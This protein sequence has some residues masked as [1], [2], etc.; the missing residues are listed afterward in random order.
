MFEST[1]T[2]QDAAGAALDQGALVRLLGELTWAP[3]TLRDGRYVRWEPVDAESA[4]AFLTV[5]GRQVSAVFHFGADGL[6]EGFTAERF[7]D[8][9]PGKP[10]VLA[11]FRGRCLDWRQ[12]GEVRV[13]F[14]VEGAWVIDGQPFTFADFRVERVEHDRPE[15]F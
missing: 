4:R 10:A 7:R 8:M 9:G 12:I 13:P 15:P 14:R 5:N 1:A 6:P 3:S 11:P 2:M